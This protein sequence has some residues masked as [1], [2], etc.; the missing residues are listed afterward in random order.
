MTGFTFSVLTAT[1]AALTFGCLQIGPAY[2][3][4][5]GKAFL[6]RHGYPAAVTEAVL[7]RGPL[8]PA[9]VAEFSQSKSAD[10]RFLVASN[11]NLRPS[12]LEP[13]VHDRDDYARSGAAFNPNLSAEQVDKLFHD[14]SHTVYC[15][16]ARNPFVPADTLVR[17]HNE[18]K[19]GLE[20]FALNPRCP[21]VIKAEIRRSGD[22][23]AKRSLR[24]TEERLRLDP[25]ASYVP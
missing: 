21:E 14:P 10:V 11:P 3:Q 20:W 12:D 23:M 1:L 15:G 24:M 4:R 22:E 13:F 8:T 17:L 2:P 18:R 9:Q 7:T 19:P 6:E 25:A 16:L 5:D